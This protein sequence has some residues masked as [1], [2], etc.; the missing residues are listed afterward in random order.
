[1]ENFIQILVFL[2][3]L[4]GGLFAYWKLIPR[5]SLVAKQLATILLVT[6]IFVITLSIITQNTSGFVYWL[7]RLNTEWNVPATLASIQLAL[8]GGTALLAAYLLDKRSSWLRLYL[9]GV[10]LVFLFLAYDEYVMLHETIWN[11]PMYYAIIGSVIAMVSLA[12]AKHSIPRIRIWFLFLIIGFVIAAIGAVLFEEDFWECGIGIYSNFGIC[13]E[14]INPIY[15]QLYVLEESLEFLGVWLALVAILGF[16]S[17]IAP[18]PSRRMQSALFV[19]PLL[20]L[21]ILIQSDAIHTI[22]EQSTAIGTAVEFESGEY[23]H[24]YLMNRSEE[25][26]HFHLYI[27]PSA[28]DFTEL[29]YS[30]HLVDQDSLVSVASSNKYTK[31]N[32]EFWIGPRYAPVHRQWIEVDTSDYPPSNR[33]L[34]VVLTLWRKDSKDYVYKKVQSSDRQLLSETQVILDELVLPPP[35]RTPTTNSIAVFEYGMIL[36]D[37]NIPEQVKAGSS[38]ELNF[39]WR[40]IAE[41]QEDYIQFLHL[42]R[43]ESEEWLIQDRQ[44]L[45]SRLPTRLWYAGLL[46][47]EVWQVSLPSNLA[48]GRY[49]L[50]TGLYD[51][52]NMS[53]VE[54][55]DASGEPVLD[56]RVS[57]G[58]LIVQS[59]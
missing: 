48:E 7:W 31:T 23:L 12:L 40:T 56:N 42:G 10:G 5:L 22:E 17:D 34:W 41:G 26:L 36:Q 15:N 2:A 9:A 27:S 21:P 20:W 11:W 44:P 43:D 8:V 19:L 53:R 13:I 39:T 28:W 32:L 59:H 24:G 58:S 16:Y 52:S 55:K 51:A 49:S 54:V 25:T 50:F 29:G 57:L 45:G 38:L 37:V 47:S 6:Q 4:I 3:Y 18:P 30:I 33:A 35:A 14:R 1:M 46:D